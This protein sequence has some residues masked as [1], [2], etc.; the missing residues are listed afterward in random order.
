MQERLPL[1][2]V[3][4]L[5]SRYFAEIFATLGPNCQHILGPLGMAEIENA[6]QNRCLSLL[7]SARITRSESRVPPSFGI[8]DQNPCRYTPD[9]A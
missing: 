1:E 8:F 4:Q 7:V 5:P 2:R 3:A 6:N 9:L